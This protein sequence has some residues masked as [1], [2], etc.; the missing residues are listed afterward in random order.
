MAVKSERT[1]E[2]LASV[3][4]GMFREIGFEKTTMRAIA[5][6]AGVS[7]GNAYYYFASKDDL[8]LEL[9]EQVQNEHAAHASHTIEGLEG[10]GDRLKAV[11][12]AG[13][14]VMAPYHGF[15]GDFISTA[16]RPS[17]PVN[18]FG[19]QSAPAREASL[20]LFHAVVKGAS[21]ALPEK[22]RN[23]LPELL[24]LA[25]MGTTLFWVHDTS[26]NQQRT[27]RLIDGLVPLIAKGISLAKIPGVNRIFD[28][29][30]NLA[31]SIRA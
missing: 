14:D 6:E 24:W 30:L 15:G 12:H 13:V 11:L 1:R 9:Y 5:N 7:V 3:A 27:R 31:R 29:V 2:M 19:D 4:L 22:L 10:F 16:I 28:D 17:S 8:V 26:E 21:P 23:D 25:Y 20:A 18:P